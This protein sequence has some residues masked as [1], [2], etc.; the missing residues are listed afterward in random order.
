M[1]TFGGDHLD[2]DLHHRFGGSTV[3]VGVP[4]NHRP[5]QALALASMPIAGLIN[6]LVRN[7]KWA[8]GYLTQSGNDIYGRQLLSGVISGCQYVNLQ[9]IAYQARV[10]PEPTEIVDTHLTYVPSRRRPPDSVASD[11]D[12][13]C[14]AIDTKRSYVNSWN[15]HSVYCYG[16]IELQHSLIKQFLA[17]GAVRLS[18]D[19]LNLSLSDLTVIRDGAMEHGWTFGLR[20]QRV[21]RDAI[22]LSLWAGTPEIYAPRGSIRCISAK[23]RLVIEV[24]RNN[25]VAVS[26]ESVKFVPSSFQDWPD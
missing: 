13:M 23:K 20:S 25:S 17:N 9:D 18:A 26:E 8:Q 1:N 10:F 5:V 7:N 12:L 15:N 4:N 21:T 24:S 2:S 19:K 14:W 6:W 3:L 16:S 11:R 22:Q